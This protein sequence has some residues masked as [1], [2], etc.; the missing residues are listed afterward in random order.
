VPLISAWMRSSIELFELLQYQPI[1]GKFWLHH[2]FSP[3]G[4]AQLATSI[5]ES[6]RHTNNFVFQYKD[7]YNLISLVSRPS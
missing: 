4:M 3:G 6:S 1:V 2:E 7:Y 5:P